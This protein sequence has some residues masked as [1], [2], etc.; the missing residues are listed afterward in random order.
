[1]SARTEPATGLPKK[2]KAREAVAE[3]QPVIDLNQKFNIDS[4]QRRRQGT[5]NMLGDV[6]SG[7]K[8][9]GS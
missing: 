8:R 2:G 1:M 9:R 7:L 3:V 4:F 6:D 5:Q